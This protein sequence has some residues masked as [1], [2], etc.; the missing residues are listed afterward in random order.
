MGIRELTL[1]MVV[2]ER[3]V[4]G[5]TGENGE[6]EFYSV[7]KT[8]LPDAGGTTFYQS[9]AKGENQYVN[10]SWNMENI[11]DLTEL[12]IVTFIQDESTKAVYQAAIHTVEVQTGTEDPFNPQQTGAGYIIY[13]DPASSWAILRFS[14]IPE[15]EVTIE[16]INNL[17]VV[18]EAKR[19]PAG[20]VMTDLPVEDLPAGIYLVRL[21]VDHEILGTSKLTII[22]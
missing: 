14:E 11:Y 17:G 19:V 1:H 10:H 21:T 18:V 5:V 22:K 12:R 9:W 8:M 20:E 15:Q 13:P 6:T 7:V 2:I 4:M 16:L 3:H